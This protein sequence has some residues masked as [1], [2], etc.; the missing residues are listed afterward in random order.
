MLSLGVRSLE[1]RCSI[2]ILCDTQQLK[3][4][5][6]LRLTCGTKQNTLSE[7]WLSLSL[8]VCVYRCYFQLGL[9][10]LV[11]IQPKGDLVVRKVLVYL[12][13]YLISCKYRPSSR[14]ENISPW[15]NLHYGAWSMT[16]NGDI[17]VRPLLLEW[18]LGLNPFSKR[19][20]SWTIKKK[21]GHCRWQDYE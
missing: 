11:V 10:D 15:I 18:R 6:W 3:N 17:R 2:W 13:I 1:S 7:P 5:E 9:T 20:A 14:M 12:T 21:K 8:R 16:D 19:Y 4:M